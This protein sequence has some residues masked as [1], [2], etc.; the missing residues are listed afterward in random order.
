MIK[1]IIDL[2][3]FI[4]IFYYVIS[5]K[6]NSYFISLHSFV[7]HQPKLSFSQSYLYSVELRRQETFIPLLSQ[8]FE[9]SFQ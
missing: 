5:S 6:I 3:Y 4:A 2:L 1:D 9:R 8:M 7:F